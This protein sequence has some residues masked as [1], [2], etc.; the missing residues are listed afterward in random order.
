MSPKQKGGGR[1]PDFVPLIK[2]TMKTAAWRA[3]SHG[4]KSLYVALKWRYNTNLQNAVYLSARFAGKELGSHKDYITRWHREL[5][6]YGFTVMVTPGHL[7]VEGAGKAAHLRLTECWY[8]GQ[9]PTRDFDRWDGT[10]FR[11]QKKQNP[12][13]SVKLR[14]S[15]KQGAPKTESRPT[16]RGHPV[17]QTGDSRVPQTGDTSHPSVPQTRDI[18]TESTVPQTGD[19]TSLTTPCIDKRLRNGRGYEAE[20]AWGQNR[21]R[22]PSP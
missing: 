11:Y 1:L 22:E 17:P 7:G 20:D 3:M 16:N 9:P 21:E 19:I 2:S 18:G 5:Q 12:P 15:H 6:H 4:A 14:V 8:K 13:P 10:K